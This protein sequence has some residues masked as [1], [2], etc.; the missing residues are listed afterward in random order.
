VP[1]WNLLSQ[2]EPTR[3]GEDWNQDRQ[4]ELQDVSEKGGHSDLGGFRNRLNHEIWAIPDVGGRTKEN[5]TKGYGRKCGR[6]LHGK[7]GD[8]GLVEEM[9]NRLMEV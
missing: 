7:A 3:Q 9:E 5:G 8:L 2:K 4:S 1:F 6:I